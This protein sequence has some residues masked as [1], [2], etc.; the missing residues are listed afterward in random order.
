MASYREVEVLTKQEVDA[1][2]RD[3]RQMK[4]EE[5]RARCLN[6][7]LSQEG[8]KADLVERLKCIDIQEEIAS[9]AKQYHRRADD[10]ARQHK[11][12]TTTPMQRQLLDGDDNGSTTSQGL[13]ST[14]SSAANKKRVMELRHAHQREEERLK[15][16]LSEH[17]RK[18]ELDEMTLEEELEAADDADARS[19]H[20]GSI[21]AKV[22][23]LFPDQHP[24]ER[25]TSFIN[26]TT[27]G[28]P[29]TPDHDADYVAPQYAYDHS[30]VGD[31]MNEYA[32]TTHVTSV[33]AMTSV[34]AVTS[35]QKVTSA[36]AHVTSTQAVTSPITSVTSAP[37]VTPAATAMMSAP[38]VTTAV[39]PST[40]VTSLQTVT[41]ALQI[42]VTSA[43][44][45]QVTTATTLAVTS[46]PKTH[47][48][49]TTTEAQQQMPLLYVHNTS[50]LLMTPA[51][52]KAR[53]AA[54]GRAN[55]YKYTG[56]LNNQQQLYA[57]PQMQPS[58]STLNNNFINATPAR[59]P[60]ETLQQ[61]KTSPA[62]ITYDQANV[63]AIAAAV[64]RAT[65]TVMREERPQQ[66]S[67]RPRED[68]SRDNKDVSMLEMQRQLVEMNQR[69][70]DS[71]YERMSL[72]APS[73]QKYDGD[74]MNYHVFNNA[75]KTSVGTSSLSDGAKLNVLIDHLQGKALAL[76]SPCALGDAQEGYARAL[77]LLKSRFGDDF[78]I[79]DACVKKLTNGP[80]IPP[81]DAGAIQEFADDLRSCV[82]TL[83]A[84][85]LIGEIDAHSR[86]VAVVD[87]LPLHLQ[88][89]WRQK[90]VDFREN[91][92]KYPDIK[93]FL[94]F[95]E[96]IATQA[97]DPMFGYKQKKETRATSNTNSSKTNKP[98]PRQPM[99]ASF[100]AAETHERTVN[101]ASNASKH[102]Y[103][104]RSGFNKKP[105]C[106]LCNGEHSL[107]KCP[108]L[109]KMEAPK[110][111]EVARAK[112]VCF[113]CLRSGGGH[114]S[115]DC[116]FDSVCTVAD[117]GSK[118][119]T[120]L[121]GGFVKRTRTSSGDASTDTD[122]AFAYSVMDRFKNARY[123]LPIVRVLVNSD[124]AAEPIETYALLDPGS[125][126][127]FCAPELIEQLGVKAEKRKMP[128][129]TLSEGALASVKQAS[130]S[131]RAPGKNGREFNLQSVYAI[132]SFPDLREC[133]TITSDVRKYEHLKNLDI[134]DQRSCKVSL[135]IGQESAWCFYPEA[136]IA[137]ATEDEPYAVKT[138]LGWCLNGNLCVTDT[139]DACTHAHIPDKCED[140]NDKIEKFW[141]LDHVAISA[142]E[143]SHSANDSKVIQR[144]NSSCVIANG[145]Y[146]LDIP[147]KKAEPSLPDNKFTAEKRLQYL[148]KKLQKDDV[149]A[150]LYSAGIADLISK[151]FAEE[152]HDSGVPGMTWYIPH[153]AVV[154]PNK[155]GKIRIVFDCAAQYGGVSLNTEV[156]QGPDLTNKLVGV[157][158][159]FREAP[160]GI[161][162]DVEAMFHQVRVTP[163]H[164][165]AL[166]FLW[167]DENGITKTYR[168][169]VHLFGGVWSP[170]AANYALQKTASEFKQKYPAVAAQSIMENFYVDDMCAGSNTSEDGLALYKNVRAMLAERR[171]NLTKWVS[172]DREL[173][174][175]IPIEQ[176]APSLA[177]VDLHESEIPG[178]RSLGLLW[179]PERDVFRINVKTRV[180]VYTKRGLLSIVSSLYDP[181][182][183]IAP[184]ILVAKKFVQHE[185]RLKHDWDDALDDTQRAALDD[186]MEQWESLK[187][188][189]IPRYVQGDSANEMIQLHHFADA[190]TVGYGT[191]SYLRV[192]QADGEVRCHFLFGKARLAPLKEETIVR[193]E[194]LAAEVAVNVDVMV[195]RELKLQPAAVYF[196]SDS[197]T[198]LG[199]IHNEDQRFR[200]FAANRIAT[201]RAYTDKLQWRHVPGL[202]NPADKASRGDIDL[203]DNWLHAPAFLSKNESDWPIEYSR[204]Q[205]MVNS[206]DKDV[207]AMFC[208]STYDGDPDIPSEVE[209][210]MIDVSSWSR[211]L[212]KVAWL[213]KA[214]L[215]FKARDN[216][217]REGLT[218][219]LIEA[220]ERVII[221]E[222]QGFSYE[223]ELKQLQAG[224]EI[225]RSSSLKSFE[226]TL[227]ADRLV[228]AT[229]RLEEAS[230]PDELKHPILLPND[231]LTV[232]TYIR[233]VHEEETGH[234]SSQYVLN[235]IR[236]KY[237]IIKPTGLVKRVVESCV[238]CTRLRRQTAKQRMAPLPEERAT[239]GKPPFT[240]TGIDCFGPFQ[241]RRGRFTQKRYG[242][243]FT[244]FAVRAIHLEVLTSLDV[245]SFI[246][247]LRRFIARRGKPE[248]LHSDNGS[249]FTGASK[250]LSRAVK[251]WNED[252]AT[253]HFLIQRTI[254]W[255]FNTPYASHHGG[256]WER[257]IRSVRR[258]LDVVLSGLTPYDEGFNTLFC[259]VEATVNS[260]PITCAPR[261]T[262]DKLALSPAD[263]ICI[264]A[265][266]TDP[267]TASY[268][269]PGCHYQ[270]RWREIQHIA[271]AFWERWV[272]EYLPLLQTRQKWTEET[273]NFEIDDVV[274]VLEE[275]MTRNRWP[276]GRIIE[277]Q[278]GSDGLVRSVRV[279][280][281][282]SEYA[283]PISKLCLLE[284]AK[285]PLV[286]L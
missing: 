273:R 50:D 229:G 37:V 238:I 161:M 135:L 205:F 110:R 54:L 187:T 109:L 230:V 160:V 153:H 237:W 266:A 107:I 223:E 87:R 49:Y 46:A 248:V 10:Y 90:A 74:P 108:D 14:T 275:K 250:E 104:Q 182:G 111:V 91:N 241:V 83:F 31:G 181:L 243:L 180:P 59:A 5:L 38:A 84:V 219:A 207:K 43:P 277:V 159:R 179:D 47:M 268:G 234:G 247:A 121:H 188:I 189:E 208:G 94:T 175:Q 274:L 97:N 114:S 201:I 281:N 144:W 52:S 11:I 133:I 259:E 29:E 217:H 192:Q 236:R 226:P 69:H 177:A 32:N 164:R 196:W 68:E 13:R 193:L 166:R 120:I 252:Q 209:R 156:Y 100:H 73:L 105:P 261:S 127:N 267:P 285:Q 28:Q 1:I 157:L 257:M 203:Y 198:V 174:E 168:L 16:Q 232:N 36:T 231:H 39:T 8:Y 186:W 145:H 235:K 279:R 239:P 22:P 258:T 24:G 278:P 72:P 254:E 199:Y 7:G 25:V 56:D 77:K 286:E 65:A 131:V 155:P 162:A 88:N 282:G 269:K 204:D 150:R 126:R 233:H 246:D 202:E 140:L 152:V 173:L 12:A 260:R 265:T 106:L 129:S 113:N 44:L 283:R 33:P 23:G 272:N 86:L 128:L 176:R 212:R 194:L 242:C 85:G 71:L 41:S 70:N 80:T 67:P 284:E 137:G 78:K 62:S 18:A 53:H 79:A 213:C 256:V 9:F 60:Y 40:T 89:T 20:L 227:G 101:T 148:Q 19:Q 51:R 119:A 132:D 3:Y 6:R 215:A 185:Y 93:F 263:L 55:K 136:T 184:F 130:F 225:S 115:R 171:F 210:Y 197:F 224:R 112:K 34:P 147:F 26:N 123:A 218:P 251:S 30:T 191:A 142:R 15:Q 45:S 245:S 42:D 116:K 253:A 146:Q 63:Q 214:A 240:H 81:Y 154:N 220:A 125:T 99:A 167:A 178:E 270:Q 195:Q 103:K 102:S 151:G 17:G 75:F 76:I 61:V 169:C 165:D 95:I 170:S 48:T 66:T 2:E 228:R 122:K 98:K 64:A 276:L 21:P 211:L 158:L 96:K 57:L 255:R 141:R 58:S 118:H 183:F 190:S 82:E 200:T 271:D 262:D 280:M 172:N 206:E 221:R 264:G 92:S 244:C 163:E 124:N 139:A 27:F 35:E 216:K 117:C 134:P 222:I 143:L 138:P 4:N 149:T 249:N